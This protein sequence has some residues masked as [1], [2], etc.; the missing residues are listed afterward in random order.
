MNKTAR[1]GLFFAAS[2]GMTCAVALAAAVTQASAAPA[3]PSAGSRPVA[4]AS[5]P[6]SQ[7]GPGWALA[8]YSASS[9]GAGAPVK[10]GPLTPL[11]GESGGRP[12]RAVH[13]AGPQPGAALDAGGLVR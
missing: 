1:R 4:A 9:G 6:W 3:G 2:A 13:L 12:V 11:P 8:E 10:L 7:L 5:V